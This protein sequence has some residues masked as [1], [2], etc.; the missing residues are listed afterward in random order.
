M[1]LEEGLSSDK[2][3]LRLNQGKVPTTGRFAKPN[4]HRKKFKHGFGLYWVGETILSILRNP[5]Y[6]GKIVD[7]VQ[8]IPALITEERW[9]RIQEEMKKRHRGGGTPKNIFL[10]RGLLR[11]GHCGST[12]CVTHTVRKRMDKED[13]VYSKYI[14]GCRNLENVYVP[15]VKECDLPPIHIG[16]MDEL[17]WNR[18]SM[19]LLSDDELKKALLAKETQSDIPALQEK[20]AELERMVKAKRLY[21][22]DLLDL[23][24]P[25]PLGI[26]RWSREEIEKD[27]DEVENDISKANSEISLLQDRIN[28]E[29]ELIK[30]IYTLRTVTAGLRKDLYKY[31]F[32]QKRELLL[33]MVGKIVVD[34]DSASYK[35]KIDRDSL[36]VSIELN[37]QI[38]VLCELLQIPYMSQKEIKSINDKSVLRTGP[39]TSR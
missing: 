2:V 31:T 4:P 9:N 27:Y 36:N 14:C 23:I 35:G 7:G 12:L 8:V 11:C 29:K 39:N 24:K 37:I 6:K 30:F 16:R 15:Y 13:Y 32:E 25:N 19:I 3:A 38:K 28:G 34:Y 1:F 33:K 26:K 17:V 20:M 18:V 5:F 22:S 10:L 21:Q